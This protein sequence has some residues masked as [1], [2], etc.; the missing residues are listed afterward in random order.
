MIAKEL[1]SLLASL[2]EDS[3]FEAIHMGPALRQYE[4]GAGPIL[5]LLQLPS[6]A[7]CDTDFLFERG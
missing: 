6:R 7:I 5:S 2:P 3:G 1:K 4:M